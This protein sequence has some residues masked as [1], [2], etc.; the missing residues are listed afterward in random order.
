MLDRAR[1]APGPVAR[2]HRGHA[3]PLRPGAGA[4]GP[5]R[6][7]A[8]LDRRLLARRPAGA[9]LLRRGRRRALPGLAGRPRAGGD[10][11][12]RHRPRPARRVDPR[13]RGL[14]RGPR[15]QPA[16][17]RGRRR[18][19]RA[20]AGRLAG[21]GGDGRR[22]GARAAGPRAA[23]RRRPAD[24]P[25]GRRGARRADRRAARR[26]AAARHAVAAR[27]C[28]R[29][30]CC[31]AA[32]SGCRRARRAG[33]RHD[34]PGRRRGRHR[35]PADDPALAG[36]AGARRGQGPADPRRG[37]PRRRPRWSA[38]RTACAS[39]GRGA[40]RRWRPC[41]PPGWRSSCCS[42]SWPTAAACAAALRIGALAMLWLPGARCCVTAAVQP[43]RTVELA[44][45]AGG[46]LLLGALTDRLVPW[47]RA[48]AVPG[49]ADRGRLRG[50]PR[51]GLGPHHPLAAGPQPALG[52]ALLRHRQR[53]RGDAP[54]AAARRAGGA[55]DRA[56]AHARAR[57]SPS[58]CRGWRW[59]WRS[60]PGAWAPTSAASSRSA[61]G[62]AAATLLMLPGGVT[63]RALA[64]AAL[65]PGLAL[66]GLAALDLATGGDGHFTR[67]VLRAAGRRRAVGH[68]HA[69]LRAGVQRPA[70]RADAVRHRPRAPRRRLRGA[71]PRA[72]LRAA[73]GRSRPGGRR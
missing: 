16:R 52:L 38:W 68:L 55:A 47:P 61:A 31:P 25:A 19:R 29:R 72:H 44:M 21:L 17:G 23:R 9:G 13:R 33:V 22:A 7:H 67:T 5:Q 63:R 6:R 42:A 41:S 73:R 58:R 35:L 48:P 54:G 65:V 40:S 45:L 10:G 43:A 3:G 18:P 12:R 69:P 53:A 8:H 49:L 4:A 60:A 46:G 70:A 20:R 34:A 50:R 15:P 59:A 57:C 64:I 51:A 26:R 56:R 27:A 2:P 71:P 24:R 28:A 30:S 14:R 1:R 32:R 11:A 37:R 39:S 66:A 36:R 62:T